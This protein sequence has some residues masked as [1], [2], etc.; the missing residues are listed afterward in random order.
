MECWGNWM[1]GMCNVGDV[2]CW[3]FGML[4]IWDVGDVGCSG[5]GMFTGLWDVDLQNAFFITVL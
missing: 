4:G 3:G 1:L 5:C 2:R